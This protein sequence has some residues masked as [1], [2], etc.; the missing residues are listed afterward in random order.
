MI[1]S[2]FR[3]IANNFWLFFCL[4]LG[5]LLITSILA[6]IPI[7]TDGALKKMLN[8]EL[9]K[10]SNQND[11][12][13]SPGEVNFN[14]NFRGEY[15]SPFIAEIIK[16]TDKKIEKVFDKKDLKI[17][18][19]YSSATVERLYNVDGAIK[20]KYNYAIQ[21]FSDFEK[22]INIIKGRVCGDTSDDGVI[23]VV[24]SKEEFNDNYYEL[25][26][27]YT[28]CPSRYGGDEYSYVRVKVVGIFEPVYT[29][30]NYWNKS[31]IDGEFKNTFVA[32][33]AAFADFYI[34]EEKAFFINDAF[35]CTNVNLYGLK[36]DEL[37]P[38]LDAYGEL[39]EYKKE[40]HDGTVDLYAPINE[41]LSE[42]IEKSNKLELTMWILNAPVIVMLLFYTYM[43]AKMVIDDDKNEIS[44]L[45]CRGAFP[46]Q[47]F[48]RY[49]I[50]CGIISII[51]LIA[52]PLLGLFLAQL[53]GSANGFL[54]FVN[55][56][57]LD[58]SI[59]PESY[60]YAAIACVVFMIMVLIP[61]H[62]ATKT[63]IVQHKQRKA[64]KNKRPLWEV[65]FLD[66]ILL[67]VSIYLLYLYQMTDL[68]TPNGKSDMTVY[69]ISTV[70]IFAC[71]M[72]FLRIYP[73]IL[74]FIYKI[75]KKHLPPTAYAT[76]IQVSRNKNEN[77]FLIMF[78]ILTMSIGIYSSNT[79]GIINTNVDDIAKY[80]SGADIV[81]KPDWQ[82]DTVVS[83]VAPD[84]T[85]ITGTM[86]DMP[87]SYRTFSADPFLKADGIESA[88]K[89]ANLKGAFAKKELQSE[90]ER[91]VRIMAIEPYSFS[92][93]SWIRP[94]TFNKHIHWYY[95]INLM[96]EYPTGVLVSKELADAC[97][98]NVGSKL[99]V[100]FLNTRLDDYTL[101]ADTLCYVMG[102]FDYW[103]TFY[104]DYEYAEV[105]DSMILM[106]FNYLET[107]NDKLTY[108]LWFKKADDASSDDIYA[109]WEKDGL[110]DKV[111]EITDRQSVL[112]EEKSDSLIM[113]LNGL[114]SMGFVATMII[115]FM[116]FLLYWLISVRKRRLQFGV[117]R[118]MGLTKFKLSLMLFWEH[119][120]TSGV[121]VVVGVVIG[122]LTS[123]M[124]LPVLKKTFT[125]MLPLALTYNIEDNIKVYIIV[126][127]M[128]ISG[129]IVLS[130]YISKL[131]INEAV[132]IGEE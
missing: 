100:S 104:S 21:F 76:F 44:S 53:I 126:A 118:A 89:V 103:P 92:Q 41:T 110:L 52:A 69:F 81:V 13:A 112:N 107:L 43:V 4:I 99:E 12:Y 78:L 86:A 8:V 90:W 87:S 39:S 16:E 51:S 9:D 131:K 59:L 32:T 105:T 79:A 48:Y 55:R 61:A 94:S 88:T 80:K 40:L 66:I 6:A 114:F 1:K 23:E 7:Y 123:Y 74:K 83:Y 95:Y 35:W 97:N 25:N 50:E 91:N 70:F 101:V 63:T 34:N 26:G 84:G 120:M 22:H 47:I 19:A 113:A 130:R 122:Y 5:S 30:V 115:S 29:D 15:T 33:K 57:S 82:L 116:G 119:L 109:Q 77:R 127:V 68:I 62:K 129:V 98:L 38:Y 18:D 31:V 72:L 93:I 67:G 14:I 2:V 10:Y 124:Y 71:G 49:L 121:A 60:L 46:A 102:I 45:K 128:I 64:R 27:V 73:Y 106:N 20:N 24:V 58:L 42:Y 54:E 85:V 17:N 96:Q 75:T 65:A 108:D 11:G 37:S 125:N 56:S 3:K 132:K 111:L 117:L 28:M 36:K